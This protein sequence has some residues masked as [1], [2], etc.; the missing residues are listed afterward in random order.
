MTLHDVL[1]TLPPVAV[2][3]Q[4]AV[5]ALL[6]LAVTLVVSFLYR[7]HN[8]TAFPGSVAT[9]L[10]LGSVAL[11][12]NTRHAF[13]QFLGGSPDVLTLEAASVNVLALA[14]AAGASAVGNRLGLRLAETERFRDGVL[15]DVSPLVR[16]AGRFTTVTL[17]E[18]I[19]D[20]EGYDPVPPETREAL[21]GATL[22]FPR[23]LTVRG[24]EEQLALRLRESHDVGYVDAEID[25]DGTVRHLGLGHRPAGLGPT[26]PPGGVA[27]AVRADPPFSATAGD[28]V[29]IWEPGPE[30]ERVG[31]GELRAAVGR[32]ATVAT[33][34]AVAEA[35]DLETRYRLATL[36]G[37]GH[38]ERDF[39]AT[40]RRADET[41]GVV[42]VAGGSPLVGVAVGDLEVSVIAVRSAD[43]TV[44]T[45]PDRTRPVA[46][47]DHLFALGRPTAL[48]ELEEAS[49]GGTPDVEAL[50]REARGAVAPAPDDPDG[51]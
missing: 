3:L 31:T 39:A 25:P 22:D 10:G 41:L 6:A 35:V 9:L 14:V 19:A 33:E 5:L 28:V 36:P 26:L 47:G 12:L 37:T 21:E 18:E 27:V 34:P 46:A 17:P 16:A 48:R 4:V 8:R 20:V 1:L 44:E 38:P 50:L 40:L 23:G 13:V 42:A 2:A 32:V 24:L 7:V 29:Q 51:H 15:L 43:G 49:G 45:V 30:P 11:V